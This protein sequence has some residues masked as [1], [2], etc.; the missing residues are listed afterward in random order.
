MSVA[1]GH[2]NLVSLLV[3]KKANLE[4]TTTVKMIEILSQCVYAIFILSI[5]C[6][7]KDDMT[8]FHI[9]AQQG[10]TEIASFLIAQGASIEGS[11]K[12]CG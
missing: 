1:N 6:F 4:A 10:F 9:A 7:I 5:H 11:N 2:K 8:P 12:V 3:E